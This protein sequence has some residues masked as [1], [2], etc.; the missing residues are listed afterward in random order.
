MRKGRQGCTTAVPCAC[1]CAR[2]AARAACLRPRP[3]CISGE[4]VLIV[5][6]LIS[7][8]A[9]YQFMELVEVRVWQPLEQGSL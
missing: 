2:A 9:S 3:H 6:Y 1:R 8:K 7:P 4:Q 5:I